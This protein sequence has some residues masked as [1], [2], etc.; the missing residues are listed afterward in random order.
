MPSILLMPPAV[1]PISRDEAKEYLRVEHNDDDDII[2]ALIVGARIHVEAQTKRALITQS[3][4]ISADRWPRD[5]RLPV[6]PAPLQSLTAARVYDADGT[7]RDIDTQAFVV[8]PGA[9]ALIF[10]PWALPAPGRAAAGI[11]LDVV[12]GYGDAATDVP[13]PLR[14]AIRV[15]VA[16]WYEN[17]GLVAGAAA[18]SAVLPA[19]FMALIAPYRVLS[20]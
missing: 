3:W 6:T 9:P 18:Q 14:Q 2:A 1:E 20:L 8:E 11:A 7:A 15:L 13:E 4:R 5:G 16:H 19:S 17:R 10:V 12:C